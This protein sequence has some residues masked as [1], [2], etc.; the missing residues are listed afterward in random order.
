MKKTF[1]YSFKRSLPVLF[2]FLPLGIAYGILMREIGYGV[3]W[4]AV[5]STFVLAGSLQFLMVSFFQ[6]GFSLLT[7]ALLS[8]SLNS[9]HIFYG[10]SFIEKFRE[11]GPAKWFLIFTLTDE[12]YSLHCSYNP[13]EGVN[14]KASRIISSAFVWFYWVLFSVL[15]ALV[16]SLINFDTTG[17]DFALTALFAT[18]LVDQV[19]GAKKPYPALIAAGMSII[20][21]FI[22]GRDNFI[23]PA[24]IASVIVLFILR[25][26]IENTLEREDVK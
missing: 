9:R 25:P 14:E 18:I 10:L 22:F 15:G 13:E 1:I 4:T 24:L 20:S 11:Y 19:R 2:G 8:L 16:G 17:L 23:L 12:S 7:V 5:C 3:G 6:G 21:L 26:K